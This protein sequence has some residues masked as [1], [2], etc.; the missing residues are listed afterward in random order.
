MRERWHYLAPETDK[1]KGGDQRRRLPLRRSCGTAFPPFP[2]PSSRPC[3]APVATRRVRV[4]ERPS[5]PPSQPAR[6]TLACWRPPESRHVGE[7]TSR[8]SSATDRKSV[9]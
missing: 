9:V 1:R 3:R 8:V 6:R 2:A 5:S 7:A 4:R